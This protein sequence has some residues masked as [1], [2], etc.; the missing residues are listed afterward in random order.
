M[1]FDTVMDE[2]GLIPEDI[3]DDAR[4]SVFSSWQHRESDEEWISDNIVLDLAVDTV[5]HLST[6]AEKSPAKTT[7]GSISNRPS[8]VSMIARSGSQT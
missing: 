7:S 2:S 5:S 6:N 8:L 1:E 3:M 4:L